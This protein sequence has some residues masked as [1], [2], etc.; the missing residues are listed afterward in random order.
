M[1][2]K[3]ITLTTILIT[4]LITTLVRSA[5]YERV[6]FWLTL[7]TLH[8]TPG[9]TFQLVGY[10]F[11]LSSG[12]GEVGRASHESSTGEET[13]L[14]PVIVKEPIA[15][16][17]DAQNFIEAVKNGDMVSARKA[18]EESNDE[19]KKYYI[20]YLNNLES[21]KLVQLINSGDY[22]TQEWTL[23]V[24]LAHIDLSALDNVFDEINLPNYFLSRAAYNADLACIPQRFIYLLGRIN[25][26]KDQEVAVRNGVAVL[27]NKHKTECLEHL[28]SALG[29][30]ILSGDLDDVAI[31]WAFS[32]ASLLPVEGKSFVERFFDHP[33]ITAESYADALH[34]SYKDECPANKPFKWLLD[35]ADRQD[36]EAA[37]RDKRFSERWQEFQ[38]AV[39]RTVGIESRHGPGHRERVA[40]AKEALDLPTV[41]LDMIG[42]Y[43]E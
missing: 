37:R 12:S 1:E 36:L 9:E 21:S 4:L 42:G 40:A 2:L 18:F 32:L 24:V 38:N 35:R 23:Q 41:L 26:S 34:D 27:F 14:V 28:V 29:E 33:A 15:S 5:S 16:N 13:L 22:E 25:N 43:I 11:A 10:Q 20:K 30:W 6:G 8:E 19:L 31:K 3:N 39:N 17:L 7:Q